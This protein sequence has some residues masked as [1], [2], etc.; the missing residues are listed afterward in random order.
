GAGFETEVGE[1]RP[2]RRELDVRFAAEVV[3]G[4]VGPRP[5]GPLLA[6]PPTV[7]EGLPPDGVRDAGGGAR[8]AGDRVGE[9]LTGQVVP[10]LGHRDRH[11]LADRLVDLRRAAPA[12]WL[13]G[14]CLV[15]RAQQPGVDELVEVE[16]RQVARDVASLCGLLPGHRTA[17]AAHVVV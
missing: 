14:G 13:S 5:D 17:L 3:R 2:G 4:V 6:E 9:D 7:V 16:R 15:P 12:A 8:P 10:P 11:T 1:R